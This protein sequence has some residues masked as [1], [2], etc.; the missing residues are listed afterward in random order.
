[1]GYSV[2]LLPRGHRIQCACVLE[3]RATVVSA[4]AA[5]AATEVSSRHVAATEVTR[6]KGPMANPRPTPPQRGPTQRSRR[7]L[8]RR[9]HPKGHHDV[10]RRPRTGGFHDA[11][12]ERPKGPS[13]RAASQELTPR[14]WRPARKRQRGE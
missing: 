12:S 10:I 5:E 9:T 4:P 3:W 7:K 11:L 6:Q 13:D 2:H 8:R 14:P 1:M